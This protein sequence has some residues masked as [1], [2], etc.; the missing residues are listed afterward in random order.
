[1]LCC[2]TEIVKKETNEEEEEE[3]S[4][5]HTRTYVHLVIFGSSNHLF[6]SI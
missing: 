1:M 5:A 4:K 3:E 2:K 6:F